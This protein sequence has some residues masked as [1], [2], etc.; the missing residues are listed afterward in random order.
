MSFKKRNLHVYR[1]CLR[2]TRFFFLVAFLKQ[3]PCMHTKVLSQNDYKVTCNNDYLAAVEA[4][5]VDDPDQALDI[6]C[7]GYNRWEECAVG[8]ISDSC[9]NKAKAEFEKFTAK[10]LGGMTRR[11][12]PSD[13]FDPKSSSCTKALPPKGTKAKGEKSDNAIS[14][15]VA[16]F[17]SFLFS[18][19]Q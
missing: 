5:E 9:G 12:C 14:K 6:M 10:M 1:D 18:P 17:A 8:K 3:S 2:L 4:T 15:Y 13:L 11:L 19:G 16:S 7:C